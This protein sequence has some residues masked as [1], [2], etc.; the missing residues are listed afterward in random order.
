MARS[1]VVIVAVGDVSGVA[2]WRKPKTR[3]AR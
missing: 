3:K 2:K 1:L